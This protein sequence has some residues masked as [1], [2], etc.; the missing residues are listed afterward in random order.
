MFSLAASLLLFA[1]PPT[2]PGA[3]APSAPSA[4]LTGYRP[5][6]ARVP[7]S[8]K[9]IRR[10]PAEDRYEAAAARW[11]QA[12]RR[13]EKRERTCFLP[14]PNASDFLRVPEGR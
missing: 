1:A 10:A 11:K 8:G 13:C 5:Q 3:A 12:Q 4:S 7:R 14:R 6:P 9:I 2:A